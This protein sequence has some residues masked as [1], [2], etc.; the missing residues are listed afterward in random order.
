MK[1]SLLFLLV[2]L[3][4]ATVLF[5]SPLSAQEKKPAGTVV[6]ISG[7]TIIAEI[8]DV[9]IS[10]GDEVEIYRRKKIIDPIS[11]KVRGESDIKIAGGV[12][13]DFGLGKATL[14]IETSENEIEIGDTVVLT[15]REKRIIRP[16]GP[17]HAEIQEIRGDN[18]IVTNFGDADEI[19]EGDVFLIQRT[20]P[21]YDPDTKEIKGT[22][23]VNVGRYTVESIGNNQSVARAIEQNM[24]PRTTDIVYKES[25]YLD[26]LAATH[27]D[28]ARIA[29]LRGEVDTLKM[30]VNGLQAS[31]DSLRRSHENHLDDFETLK[32]DIE[33]VLPR[34]VSGD[35]GKVRLMRKN[36][37]PGR[38]HGRAVP[39]ELM[40]EY[41]KALS[42]CLDNKLKRA[43]TAFDDIIRRWPDSMLTENCRYWIAQSY[44]G[45]KLYPQA[46]QGFSMVVEDTRF[47][48]KDD[49]ASI[50]LGITYYRMNQ[51]D[52]ARKEFKRFISAYPD[53]EYVQKVRYWVGLLPS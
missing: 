14:R 45:L 25:E 32:A 41:R 48:H 40:A 49:D 13:V 44:Y 10:G 5:L 33:T 3:S 26:Y 34:L 50:M 51:Y 28:S 31:L 35:I 22:N 16:T 8:R 11:G 23:T 24:E 19:S 17:R 2:A 18:T 47:D 29:E 21:V 53:S 20:E 1:D 6:S 12:I 27:S 42:L 37:E 38:I 7:K 52:K 30:R 36:D 9:S 39:D 43:V 15:G 46:A 4:G